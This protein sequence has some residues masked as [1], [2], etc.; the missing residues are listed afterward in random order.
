MMIVF[1][2]DDHILAM[3]EPGAIEDPFHGAWRAYHQ[4]LVDAGIYISGHALRPSS[5]ATTV[6]VENGKRRVQDG[7]F[8]ESREQLGGFLIVDVPT[9]DEALEWAARCPAATY[10][11]IEI[12][13][14]Y[15]GAAAATSP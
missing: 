9:L 8:A 7:P 6:R 4:A 15:A 10:G 12:R 3:E 11:T 5:T 2:T 13:P 14:L 1:E